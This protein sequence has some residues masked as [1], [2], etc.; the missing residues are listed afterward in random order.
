[1]KSSTRSLIVWR[2]IRLALS[3]N[4]VPIGGSSPMKK[5][6]LSLNSRRYLM[7]RG[8]K[9]ICINSWCWRFFQW[10]YWIITFH[11]QR[12]LDLQRPNWTRLKIYWPVCTPI[13]NLLP[14]SFFPRFLKRF[15]LVDLQPNCSNNY[16]IEKRK[17][18]SHWMASKRLSKKWTKQ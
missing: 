14:S 8:P 6:T 18:I 1:M 10:L 11:V 17:K 12:F 3:R 15:C 16:K 9:K 4:S 2:R 13:C 5:V 7:M